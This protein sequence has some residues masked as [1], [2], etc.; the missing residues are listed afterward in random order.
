MSQTK[1]DPRSKHIERA[2]AHVAKKVDAREAPLVEAFIRLYYQSVSNDDLLEHTPQDLFGAAY[3]HWRFA[4]DRAPGKPAIRIYN[5]SA[6]RDGWKSTHTVCQMVNDDMP[7]LVDSLSMALSR[8]GLDIHLTIH[9]IIGVIRGKD[10]HIREVT[11]ASSD[12]AGKAQLESFLHLEIDR[13]TDAALLAQL[14]AE[15][16]SAMADVQAAVGDWRAMRDKA[17]QIAAGLDHAADL[18]LERGEIEEGADFLRWLTKNHFTFLGYREYDLVRED[19]EDVLCIVGGSGLG[20]LRDPGSDKV[21]KSFL[22]LPK[23][24]RRRARAKELLI[25]TKANSVATVHRPGYLD[26]IG[27]KRFNA[28]GEVIGECRFLGLFTSTAYSLTARDVPVL[29]HK[30]DTVL[31]RSGLPPASHGGKALLH[32]LETFPRDELFQSSV[33]DLYETATGVLQLQERQRVKLFIRRDAFGRFYSCLVYVPRDRYTTQIR[34]RVQDI[35]REYLHGKSVESSVQLSESKLARVHIIVRT[36]PWQFP[37][38][39]QREIERQLVLAVR[40]WQDQL[41]D[42]LIEKFGEERGVKLYHRYGEH[43]HA[44]YQEDVKPRAAAYDVEQ[45]DALT[46]DDSLRMSLYRP[47]YNPKSLLRF[48]LFRREQPI[49]ISTA[50]PM[51]EKMGM[52]VI[53]ERPY[54][55]ELSDETLIWIQDFEM[56]YA[57]RADIDPDEVK[58]IFQDAFAQIWSRNVENDGFN[59]LVLAAGLTWRETSLLRAYCKYLLQTGA[60]FSQRYM[61]Q[62]LV[63]NADIA[64]LLVELFDIRLDPAG[65]GKTRAER[66][67]KCMAALR[68]KLDSVTSLDDD[69]ILRNFVSV[70]KATLRTNYFQTDAQKQNKPYISFKFDPEKIPELPLPRPMYEI[71]VYSPRFEAVHLRGGKVA[72][73]GIRWS[74]RR[75][76][77]RTEVLGLMKAQMVKN[78]VIVPVG[79]KGGFIVKRPPA[80]R[81]REKLM[82]EVISCYQNFMRGMLDL[83]DNLVDGKVVPPR[84]VIRHD[85]DDPYLVVAADKGTATFSDIANGIAAEYD[86]WLGDAFASGGSAGYDHKGMGITARG[87]WE[88]VKRHFRELDIDTQTADFTA[89]GIGDMAGDVF[90]NG[91]LLSRHIRLVAAFNHMHVFLDPNPDA[92]KSFQERERLFNLPRSTWEDYDAAVISRGGGVYP[93]SAK[94]IP[95]SPEMRTA[96]DVEAESLT[97]Q[98]LIRAI[99][100]A[101]VDLLWNGGIGT[102]VKSRDETSADVGDRANDALRVN[103]KELRC[104]VVGEGGNLG[105]TQRGRIEYALAGGRLNTDF[106]DNS[107]GVDTSDHEVNI[108]ILLNMALG[109]N[110]TVR[111]RN[112]LLATMTD[113][114]AEL[115]LRNNY[116]QGQAITV[117]ESQA[118]ERIEEHAYLIRLLER[119]GALNRELEYLPNEEALAERRALS[120]GLTRPELSVLL[121]YSKITVYSALVDSDV[122]E[123][124]YLGQ[125]LESYFPT[126]LQ[127]D[128]RKLMP[129]HR[130]RR[131]I[132]ATAITNSIVNRMG[133]TFAH[134]MREETGADASA[135][136]RAY[137]IAREAYAMRGIWAEIEALDNQVPAQVQTAMIARTSRLLRHGTRW[138]LDHMRQRL[139][140][141]ARVPELAPG[142]VA[143]ME[144]VENILPEYELQR[145]RKAQQKLLTVG[146]PETLAHKIAALDPLYAG[147]DIVD[148]AAESGLDV[149]TAGRAYFKLGARL[150]INW[151]HEQVEQL[152]AR[153]HWQAVARGS[154]REDLYTQHR[155]LTAQVLSGYNKRDDIDKCLN[156]WL[157]TH[158]NRVEHTQRVIGDMKTAGVSSDFPTL[159][160]A[161]QEIRKLVQSNLALA[162]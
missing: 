43:F 21:S 10:R 100:K 114:I 41:Y 117:A 20:I 61:E 6:Q 44:S 138:L 93:R 152:Q 129:S 42:A 24:V 67:E 128:Y 8:H 78:T 79:S 157:N 154:L 126:P 123:D 109:K 97:P 144:A 7:F 134:R 69:R 122:P 53:S 120:R 71:F 88:S 17:G 34:E 116:L 4:Q 83:T 45:I 89:V 121:A 27:V 56:I 149:E 47:S 132:I 162:S 133:P 81:D 145:F 90:G 77:F 85:P 76:D 101:P 55:M 59:K 50:L 140:I 35:L 49:S 68:E 64:K 108:K 63:N 74:D 136:A 148:V 9:P 2:L 87:G 54:Q 3:A 23:D 95:V 36:T 160:V 51:L 29:R 106:V 12:A 156:K 46:D 32:I 11:A 1:Q 86:Y 80:D 13:Q 75:E 107:A 40:S 39:D 124:A 66:A 14:E 73:G 57:R 158:Q 118:A 112:R 137:T 111:Q 119:A 99:L 127:K 105:L 130:L 72:R 91:M 92:E 98:E 147:M 16:A 135:V 5:P 94:Q 84:D 70:I 48:K 26:Y 19:D 28:D 25:I 33:G 150:D 151:L 155:Q 110:F 102:Y 15:I 22:V 38:F 141:S 96:L 103:G 115:V 153:G 52:N 104:R 143:L 31:K 161:V 142:V 159:S 58:G 60:P 65:I 125:E 131:E 82:K 62:T 37:Q 113:E 139:D 18:P 30:V 146:V